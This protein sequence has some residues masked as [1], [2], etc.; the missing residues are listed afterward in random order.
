MK[1]NPSNVNFKQRFNSS[2][3]WLL[4]AL[5]ATLAT[6]NSIRAELIPSFSPPVDPV[7]YPIVG[8]TWT[9]DVDSAHYQPDYPAYPVSYDLKGRPYIR[10]GTVVWTINDV[11]TAWEARDAG[12]AIHAA[13]PNWD[14]SLKTGAYAD[15]RVLFDASGNAYT[16]LDTAYKNSNTAANSLKG[17]CLLLFSTDKCKTWQRYQVATSYSS[18]WQTQDQNSN[19]NLPPGLLLWNND[20]A[21]VNNCNFQILN[22]VKNANNT[23]TLNK[24][25]VPPTAGCFG[26][27]LHSGG[28][29][30]ASRGNNYFLVWGSQIGATLPKTHSFQNTAGTPCYATTVDRTTGANTGATFLGYAGTTLDGHNI[31]AVT[32]TSNGKVHALVCGHNDRHIYHLTSTAADSTSSFGTAI[33]FAD[34]PGGKTY[35]S[36]IC[37]RSDVLHTTFR[38]YVDSDRPNLGCCRN[39]TIAGT[40]WTAPAKLAV[41]DLTNYQVWLS[42]LTFC[43]ANNSVTL[44]FQHSPNGMNLAEYNTYINTW[45]G[46][47]V[48]AEAAP[49]NSTSYVFYNN[50]KPHWP[51]L[52][53]TTDAGN[54]WHIPSTSFFISNILP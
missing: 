47:N 13:Y 36:L 10:Q 48:Q 44:A 22:I 20:T 9:S 23:L 6:H 24:I 17:K 3:R 38:Y 34:Q 25:S 35:V 45:P 15:E 49:P 43:K 42:K 53:F 8:N 11:N 37:G 32:S 7:N 2:R 19:Y 12:P 5:L 26:P 51:A 28:N 31:P 52:L 39:N 30:L 29:Q 41:P 50:V 27:I 18:L 46:D 14:G 1:T 4:A 16:Y 40:G 54:S 21:N 33:S